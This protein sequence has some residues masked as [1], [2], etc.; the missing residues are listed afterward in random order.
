MK[1][2]KLFSIFLF[3]L[4]CSSNPLNDNNLELNDSNEEE[5]GRDTPTPVVFY[6]GMGDTSH[7][8]IYSVQ[9]HLEER[10]PGVY[11]MSIRM[12]NNTA[13]D[14]MSGY[15]M[16]LNDQVVDACRQLTADKRL[17]NGFNAIGFSQGGQIL[18]AIAQ[19]CPS[20]KIFNLISIGGQHQGMSDCLFDSFD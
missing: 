19:R 17:S 12:G 11:V 3:P 1:S 7:G 16:N 18:R 2:N 14:L 9:K 5:S 8:S 13:E 15:F 6:H 10:I 20:I 4:I